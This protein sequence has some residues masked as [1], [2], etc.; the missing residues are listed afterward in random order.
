MHMPLDR[1][2]NTYKNSQPLVYMYI[3]VYIYIYVCIYVYIIYCKCHERKRSELR[4]EFFQYSNKVILKLIHR[5][6]G[7]VLVFRKSGGCIITTL[8]ECPPSVS[9]L[10]T[11]FTGGTSTITHA[12]GAGCIKFLTRI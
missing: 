3:C 1:N 7:I 9:Q 10:S 12:P 8:F 11:E 5:L 6:L 2:S 4:L